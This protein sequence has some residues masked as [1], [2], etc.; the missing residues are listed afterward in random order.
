[1]LDYTAIKDVVAVCRDAEQRFRG[2]SAAAPTPALKNLFAQLSLEHGEFA[3][4]LLQAGRSMGMDIPDSSG[5]GG[6]LH[7]GWIEIKAALSGHDERQIVEQAAHGEEIC[8]TGYRQ[9]LAMSLAD[10]VRAILQRQAARVQQAHN[11][12]L[13]LRDSAVE[14]TVEQTHEAH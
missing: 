10:E 14:T 1:M 8:L 6:T 13:S 11:Q 4:E 9:A 5:V 12:I 7:S 3:G 2:A